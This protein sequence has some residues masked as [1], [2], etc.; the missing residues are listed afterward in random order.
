MSEL[1][2]TLDLA[3]VLI[4]TVS[5]CVCEF[6]LL[7]LVFHCLPILQ[8]PLEG[9]LV[10]SRYFDKVQAVAEAVQTLSTP[11]LIAVD[12]HAPQCVPPNDVKA[13]CERAL[14]IA[15]AISVRNSERPAVHL[16]SSA[17]WRLMTCLATVR[18][19]I[20]CLSYLL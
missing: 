17:V 19:I 11:H 2:I 4:E 3:P 13:L 9:T 6:T 10:C 18:R 1:V 14:A 7:C 12:T 15:K 20:I 5:L 8:D 16:S